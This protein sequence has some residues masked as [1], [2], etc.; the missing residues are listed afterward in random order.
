MI[1][2]RP[3]QERDLGRLREAYVAGH[4]SVLYVG[5]TGSGK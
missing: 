3:Y 4:R 5:V 2:L 1:E